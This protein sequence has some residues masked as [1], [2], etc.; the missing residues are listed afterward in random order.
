M[1]FE[2]KYSGWCRNCGERIG[3]G[4]CVDYLHGQIVHDQCPDEIE[5]AG[6]G[7]QERKCP[8]C[9]LTHAGECF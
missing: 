4:D 2:A 6:P 8:D 9:L 3:L 7:R 5:P 1:A